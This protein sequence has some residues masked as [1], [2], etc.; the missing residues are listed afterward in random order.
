MTVPIPALQPHSPTDSAAPTVCDGASAAKW[1]PSPLFVVLSLYFLIA[2]PL[3]WQYLYEV[4]PD[5]L[6]YLTIARQYAGLHLRDAINAYWSPLYSWL[7]LPFVVCG[8]GALPA[9]KIISVA[10]GAGTLWAADR[11][12]RH[13]APSRVGRVVVGTI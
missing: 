2:L 11:V 6:A 8:I 4:D 10:A 12:A 3:L 1:H 13:L 9:A 7:M 5:S